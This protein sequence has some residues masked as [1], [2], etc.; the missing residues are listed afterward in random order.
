MK[1]IQMFAVSLLLASSALAGTRTIDV[2]RPANPDVSVDI[3]LIAG[4][5]RIVA[6]N[7]DEVR[8]QG[9]VNDSYEEFEMR[10]EGSD[11]SIEVTPRKGEHRNIRLEA[12]LEISLPAGV[13]LSFESVSAGLAIDDLTGRV[14]I[15][16]VSGSFEVRGP[17]REVEVASIS[18]AIEL[19]AES[20]LRS[21]EIETVSGSIE[22]SGELNPSGRYSFE[23]VTGTITLHLPASAA[24]DYDIE[25]FSGGIRNDFGPK[26]TRNSEYLPSMSLSFST[27]S[28]GA[29]IRAESFSGIV[30]IVGD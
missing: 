18:G 24:A 7:R 15:E 8:V 4:D 11:I 1:T 12:D 17:L 29:R 21:V 13:R 3:E 25:T 5:V 9:T 27:G 26:A 30:R 16:S 20:T 2:S 6:W 10:G 19:V 28:R 14:Q 22:M 23:S